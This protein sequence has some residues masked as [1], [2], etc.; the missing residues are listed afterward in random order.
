MTAFARLWR[1]APAWRAAMLGGLALGGLAA[2]YP[3][4]WLRPLPPAARYAGV[5]AP[6]PPPGPF[7]P[8]AQ[9]F[10]PPAQ[11]PAAPLPVPVA[12][13]DVDLPRFGTVVSG[14]ARFGSFTVPLPRGEWRVIASMRGMTPKGQLATTGLLAQAAGQELRAMVLVTTVS[15]PPWPGDGFPADPTCQSQWAFHSRVFSAVDGGPQA[16]WT[17]EAITPGDWSSPAT[18]PVVRAGLA[19][20]HGRGV[21]APPV[22]LR[23]YFSHADTGRSL[24]VQVLQPAPA[25]SGPPYGWQMQDIRG[26]PVKL[27]RM[28]RLRDW[29]SAWHPLV[30]QAFDGTLDP[31]A[32]AAAGDQLPD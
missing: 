21:A 6:A 17:V 10:A 22:V 25:A 29:A 20:L 7:A 27:A 19:E 13:V 4:P 9:P 31:A 3:P 5:P 8:P 14:V 28:A 30:R 15:G 16:C 1:R 26:T 24:S 2:L 12:P 23:A 11:P 32:I 18:P